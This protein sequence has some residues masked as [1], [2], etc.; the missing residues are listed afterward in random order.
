MY[1]KEKADRAVNFIKSLKLSDGKWYGN[2]FNLMPW[3]EK[4]IRDIFGTIKEDGTRQYRT[5]YI[6]VPRKNGKTNLGAGIALYLLFADSEMGSEIYSA[7]GDRDQATLVYNVASAMIRQSPALL[8]RCKII[9]STKRIVVYSTNS[10]YRVLSAEHKTKHGVNAHGVIFDELHIQPNRDLW[11]VLTTSSGTRT[12]PLIVAITTAGYDKNSVCWEQHDYALKVK[13]GVIKDPTFYPVIY[14]AEEGDD[15]EDEKVWFKANPALGEFRSLD[16]MR[17]LYEKAKQTPALQNTFK[18]LYLNIWTQQETRW[19]PIE[20]WDAC[21]DRINPEELEGRVCYGGLDLSTTTDLSAF[22]L[23]FP[24]DDEVK[25]LPFAFI[26]RERMREKIR[27]DFVNYDLWEQQGYIIATEGNVVDYNTIEAVI[28]DCLEK[29]QVKSIAYDRWNA[30][31]TVQD[32]IADGYEHM[33]PIG[34]GFQSLNAPTKYL[35]TL[36]LNRQLNHGGNPLLRWNFDNVMMTQDP[37]GNI[38]PDK[39]KSNQRI[40]AIVALIMALDGVIRNESDSSSV[41]DNRE[42][43]VL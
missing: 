22:V 38:K 24:F 18:R 37:A 30:T 41:Y 1:N 2:H 12:Q 40:D 14:A 11:D 28:K 39:S 3:Q 25:V 43:L 9:D 26:P 15:W 8:K 31:K 42:I 27:V 21:P 23:A 19:I 20:K 4:I 33:I 35:E 6:E 29:Y 34:Q 17:S 7:A 10:F 16:E 36:I 32:L 13:N 5:A